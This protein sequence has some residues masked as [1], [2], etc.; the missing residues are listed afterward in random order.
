MEEENKVME[1]ILLTTT[2]EKQLDKLL[3]RAKELV[4]VA[5]GTTTQLESK[6]F[7]RLASGHYGVNKSW[8]SRLNPKSIRDRGLRNK[9]KGIVSQLDIGLN[10]L[11]HE[12]VAADNLYDDIRRGINNIT[13]LSRGG[14]AEALQR[15]ESWVANMHARENVLN[16]NIKELQMLTTSVAPARVEKRTGATGEQNMAKTEKPSITQL[17]AKLT[18]TEDQDEKRTLRKQLRALGHKG[19]LRKPKP[20]PK[21]AVAK[22]SHK[23]LVTTPAITE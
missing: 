5:R 23:K 4:E 20:A 11:W 15:L 12:R 2:T 8:V 3:S 6:G 21:K 22:K 19:G 18:K 17:M 9:I 14:L 7:A 13:D 16:Y 10:G 1:N